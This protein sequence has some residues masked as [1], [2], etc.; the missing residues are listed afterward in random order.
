MGAPLQG[1]EKFAL[2]AEGDLL[3]RKADRLDYG[4]NIRR[5]RCEMPPKT[6]KFPLREE[7]K[8]SFFAVFASLFS[9]VFRQI[10]ADK[11]L[12][13]FPKRINLV[14]LDE[15]KRRKNSTGKCPFILLVI[16]G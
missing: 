2:R 3:Q 4:E 7:N 6:S 9:A 11:K 15:K 1:I 14:H 10:I 12:V 13:F 5:I 8:F 16:A